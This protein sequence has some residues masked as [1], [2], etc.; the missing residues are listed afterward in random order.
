[1]TRRLLLVGGSAGSGKST[2]ARSLASRLGAGWL[3]LDTIW[4]AEPEGTEPLR[5]LIVLPLTV[6]PRGVTWT[7]DGSGVIVAFQDS[8]S[9]IVLFDLKLP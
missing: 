7:A 5:R 2:V 8:S 1:M 3:Q 6:R 9:D 4:V